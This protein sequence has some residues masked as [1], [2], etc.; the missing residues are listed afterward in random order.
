MSLMIPLSN[1][2]SVD[3]GCVTSTQINDE[4]N[5]ITVRMHDGEQYTVRCAYGKSIFATLDELVATINEA[6]G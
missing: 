4:K 5:A 1:N 6:R 2:V 3:A